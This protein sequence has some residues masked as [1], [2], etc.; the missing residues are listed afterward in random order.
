MITAN[1]IKIKTMTAEKRRSAKN[2]YF[3][4]YIIRPL[5]YVLTIPFLYTRI[6]PNSITLISIIPLFAGFIFAC[7]AESKAQ[8]IGAWLCFFIWNLL[9]SVDGNIARYKKQFSQM[10]GVYD[11]MSGY[12]AWVL[13]YSAFGVAAGHHLGRMNGLLNL[14]PEIYI[15]LGGLSGSFAILPRLV[16]HKAKSARK[17]FDDSGINDKANFSPLKI[18]GL[19]LVSIA[20]LVQV[21][22]LLSILLDLLDLFTLVYFLL[23]SAVMVVSLRT[24]FK[25]NNGAKQCDS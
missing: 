11:A 3:A 1:E 4:F 6:S 9:D 17:D 15:I 24:I 19:N 12:F 20:G 13:T 10:G 14:N 22:L 18:A 16:M 25:Q 2:N 23:N 21:F 5:S 8:L 7:A